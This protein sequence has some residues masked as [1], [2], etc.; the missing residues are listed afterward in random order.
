M[1]HRAGLWIL[2]L[3]DVLRTFDLKSWVCPFL[4][5][6]TLYGGCNTRN[7][8]ISCYI[9]AD[10]V[11]WDVWIESRA[12]SIYH[13]SP[14]FHWTGIPPPSMKV[15]TYRLRLL[16]DRCYVHHSLGSWEFFKG[17]P[18]DHYWL[19]LPIGIPSSYISLFSLSLTHPSPA[20]VDNQALSAYRHLSIPA[21]TVI[22]FL[23][24]IHLIHDSKPQLSPCK[25]SQCSTIIPTVVF[26][27][28]RKI[29][30]SSCQE[31]AKLDHWCFH[32]TA[33]IVGWP[34]PT[35]TMS[36]GTRL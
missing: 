23:I 4:I 22:A 8:R 33:W 27:W 18:T 35:L 7:L 6:S 13:L 1:R 10:H 24:P 20:Q 21:F 31:R 36:P 5:C 29:I 17:G 19:S 11:G 28:C 30:Y 2:I 9:L 34:L 26:H 16:L 14:L 25:H 15:W 32:Q 12:Q 3:Y